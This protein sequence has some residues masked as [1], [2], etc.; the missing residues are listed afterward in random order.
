MKHFLISRMCRTALCIITLLCAFQTYGAD[1]TVNSADQFNNLSLSP[2][3]IVTWANGTYSSNQR[4]SF[5]A[6]GT[7]SNPI[8]LRAETPGGVIFTG[9]TN[10]DI[11]GNYVIIDGFYWNGGAGSNNHIQFR[12]SSAYANNSTIR[13]CAFNNLTPSGTDKHRWIVLYGTNNTIENCSFLNKNSPGALI[14]VELE[15]NDFNPVGHVIKDNYF[16]NFIK[17]DPSTTHSGDSETIRVGTS[18]FQDKSASVTVEGNYFYK[19]DGENEIITNKSAD[20]TYRNNTFRRCRG[21]LVMRHGARATVDGNYFLGE[22]VEGTGGIRI[23][24]SYHVITNNYIQDVVSSG[25]KWNN[26]ITLVGGSDTSGG[27]TNGYQ[28]VDD[29]VVENNTLYNVDSPIFYNDRSSYDPSGVLNNN[30]IYTTLTNILSGDISGTGQSMTYNGNVY[31]GASLGISDSGFTEANPEFSASGEIYSA[32]SSA[33]SGKGSSISNPHT[34]SMVGNSVGASFLDASGNSASGDYLTVS[35]VEEFTA[36]GSTKTVD[37]SSSINWTVSDNQSWISVSLTSSNGNGSFSITVSANTADE[38]RTGTVTVSGSGVSNQTINVSQAGAEGNS[39]NAGIPS[40]LMENCNQWKITY[41][42]GEEDK[43]LCDEQGNEFFYVNDEGNAIVFRAPVR[44]DNGT[45][46]NSDNIRSELREREEDGSKDVYWTTE[47][48]HELYVKQAITHLPINKSHLV[49]TQIHGDKAAGIDDSMV[50]RLEGSHL[51]LSFNGGKL[52]SNVTIT[53]NYNLGDVHEVIFKVVDGKHYC[54]YA[55]DG[56][57]K[58]AYDSGNASQ[59]LVRA[60]GNDYV[61]DINYNQSYFKVGNYTQSN[62]EEEG[63]DTDDPDNYGEVLVYDFSVSHGEGGEEPTDPIDVTGVAFSSSSASISVGGAQALNAD[64]SPLNASNQ[65]VSYSSSNTSVATVNSSGVVTAVSEGNATITVTTEDGDFTDTISITVTEPSND[66]NLALNKSASGTGTADGNHTVANL[67]DGDTGTRWSVSGMPQSATIDLGATF[68]LGS[69]ELVCYSDRAYQY[70]IS[71]SSSENG[72]FTEVVN[73]S[74][75]ST[76]G[77]VSSPISDAFDSVE[78]R[79]VKINVTGAASYDGSWVSLLELRVFAGENAPSAIAVTSVALSSSNISL[80]A[81]VTEQLS[82]T[83]SPSDATNQAVTYSSSN[84]SVATVNSTGLVTALSEGSATITVTTEDGD[85]TDSVAVTVNGSQNGTAPYSLSKFQD[86]LAQCKLQS[87]LSGTEA[88]ASDI[89]SGYSSSTFYVADGNKM[90]FYQSRDDA[91]TRQRTELRFLENWNVNDDQ[92][93][94]ANVNIVE[95]TCEQLTFMQIHDDANAGDGPNKPLLRVYQSDGHLYAAVKT[96]DGGSNTSHIDLG[97][98]PSGYFDCDIILESGYMIVEINGSEKLN[99]NVSFWDYP[100]YWKNGV[101]LQDTGEATVYFNELTLTEAT[102]IPP[103]TESTNVALEKSVSYST[104][105]STNPASNLVDGD[106]DSRWSAQ[107]FPVNATVDLG[108][109][110]MVNSTEV[111][112]HGDRA[113]QY[114]I[115]VSTDG[116]SFSEVVNRSNNTTAGTN[117]A[118]IADAFSNTQARYVRLTVVGANDYDGDWASID[119]L[120]VFGYASATDSRTIADSQE[121]IMEHNSE[122]ELSL[123]PNPATNFINIKGG[124]AYHTITVYDQ[125]GKVIFNRPIQGETIDISSLN[126]GLYIFRLSG[127]H[128]AISKRIIKK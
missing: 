9:Q 49:A 116:N 78:A 45:T 79:F 48:T 28:K 41:P 80:D 107:S 71:V 99:T 98:T 4:I 127:A 56:N 52:R 114:I 88:T 20:N 104:Q 64:V 51:F 128:N 97:E 55:E 66:T 40:D 7:A 1:Y 108:S 61:M 83:V 124:K 60:D 32:S 10:M 118:P 117:S 126:S 112:C 90:A 101:Y 87:P 16:F 125:V 91:S 109:L 31:Y 65:D 74:S 113:Y 77:S 39:G 22:N 82:A 103:T 29:I 11:S 100:S 24:D 27:I 54:Y 50:M 33:V 62:P 123:Y 96:D 85:F 12:K 72:S 76:S 84:T 15:Y 69:T 81:N 106:E 59:Y 75:N 94:H 6:N 34:H 3:D 26:G 110:H 120:R 30:V 68:T 35:S 57:L 70:T 36:A 119:E 115:E 5:T 95:Q 19:A 53:Q 46:P 121:S 17:R 63:D 18:E 89:V 86:Y 25:D 67:V 122:L 92:V 37:V 111:I 105:Q 102:T 8:I 42:T 43:T 23:T 2:G 38:A 13:N 58:N 93:F 44:S 47:G 73:R 21:S 14:L